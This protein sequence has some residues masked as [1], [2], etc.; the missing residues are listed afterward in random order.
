M[1]PDAEPQPA[2]TPSSIWHLHWQAAVGRSFLIDPTLADRIK[3]RLVTAH[4]R[5]GR[6]LVDYTILP[7]EIHLIAQI[8]AGDRPGAVAGSIGNAISR[9]VHEVHQVRSPVMA[10]PFRAFR[11]ESEHA[12]RREM[13]MLAWRPVRLK[14]CRGPTFHPH[15]ALRIALGMRR[16]DG[17]DSRPLL[18]LFGE[19]PIDARPALSKWMSR[20][21]TE[22]DWRTWELARGLA[23]APSYGGPRPTGFRTMRTPEAASLVAKAGEGGVKAALCLLTHW[24]SS[25]IAP[26]NALDLHEGRNAQ[27][28]RGRSLVARVAA[29]HLLCS[30]AFVARYFSRAKATLSEQVA[31]S[32]LREVDTLLVATPMDR[33]LQDLSSMN[34]TL[35]RA[36]AADSAG[37]EHS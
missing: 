20:R 6:V 13:R 31:A 27:A 26:G 8:A 3:D 4:S 14:L 23:L 16:S 18:S 24:V 21:P 10:G 36:P 2:A 11:L 15:N 5:R 12:M 37:T 34:C 28:V 35:C 25:R 9:W 7:T 33:I 29:E 17:F 22:Q 32:R 19:N 1:D 30:S